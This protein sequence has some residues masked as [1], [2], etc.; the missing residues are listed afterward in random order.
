MY[1]TIR[2]QITLELDTLFY[3]VIFMLHTVNTKLFI[4]LREIDAIG[5]IRHEDFLLFK[6]K[7]SRIQCDTVSLAF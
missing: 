3:W 7:L 2:Q 4:L 6:T 5:Y 1:D